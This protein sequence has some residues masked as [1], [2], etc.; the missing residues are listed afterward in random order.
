MHLS[1]PIRFSMPA[2]ACLVGVVALSAGVAHAAITDLTTW[3]LVEDPPAQFLSASPTILS[4]QVGMTAAAGPV[5]AGADIGYQ[6]VDGGTVATS[7][8]GWYFDASAD[9]AVAI[10]YDMFFSTGPTGGLA[11]GFGIGTDGG[12]ANSAGAGL[13]TGDGTSLAAAAAGRVGY[14]DQPASVLALA[15]SLAGSFHVAYAAATGNVTV[16]IGGVGAGTPAQQFTYAGIQDLWGE[17]DLLVSF[18]LRSTTVPNP[19]GGADLYGPW[20]GGGEGSVTFSDFRVLDGSATQVPEPMAVA[21]LPLLAGG[22]L[23]RRR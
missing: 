1:L 4:S 7:T 17:D 21:L 12:G 11:I 8:G 18:F 3:T 9:F 22:L 16:G 23:R 6:S 19:F 20:A 13:V 15:P 5:P 14:V 2:G 10:D